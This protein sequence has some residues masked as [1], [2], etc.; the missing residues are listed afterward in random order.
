MW[1]FNKRP[2]ASVQNLSETEFRKFLTDVSKTSN[3]CVR[4]RE[5]S[6][7]EMK[8]FMYVNT[9]N[10]SS[11]F[12][13]DD[14]KRKHLQVTLANIVEFEIN[15]QFDHYKPFFRYKVSN[16]PVAAPLR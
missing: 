12:L 11:V 10:G 16:A 1:L 9:V 7:T 6:E 2:E 3:V 13:Y 15:E 14:V 5:A 8:N 4:L